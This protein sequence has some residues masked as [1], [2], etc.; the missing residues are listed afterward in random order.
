MPTFW[1][2]AAVSARSDCGSRGGRRR[3]VRQH[4]VEPVHD[5]Q[6]RA[7]PRHGPAA[8]HQAPPAFIYLNQVGGND[9]LIF[10]G[11]SLALRRHRRA[12]ADAPATSPRIS[13]IVD[14]PLAELKLGPRRPGRRQHV[15]RGRSL[16]RA[17]AWPPR[18]HA[19][20]RLHARS[21]SGLSG[22]IDSA[23]TAALA[24]DALGP[25]HVT[26]VAMPTRYSSAAFAGR[27]RG[28]GAEPRHPVTA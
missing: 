7:A 14:H 12:R 21:C 23:L 27:R 1:R 22:G 25:S 2:A 24:A 20:V 3:P 17:D 9:E 15:A 10:D 6:G 19:Q 11:H 18:L 16:E 28:A 5:G 4:L 13:S 8:G 26:G